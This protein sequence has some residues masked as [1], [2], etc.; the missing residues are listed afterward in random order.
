MRVGQCFRATRSG[1]S[2]EQAFVLMIK[3]DSNKDVFIFLY[4]HSPVFHFLTATL[5]LLVFGFQLPET[6]VLFSV[7]GKNPRNVIEIG[8]FLG[9][10]SSGEK[11]IWGTLF[12]E[13]HKEEV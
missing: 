2:R 4:H 13:N 3:I 11:N 5:L 7:L 9:N 1:A 6:K 8:H 10:F 12:E